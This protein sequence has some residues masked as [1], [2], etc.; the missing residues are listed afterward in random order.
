MTITAGIKS[1]TT[2]LDW[3]SLAG[4]APFPQLFTRLSAF[5][6]AV[7]AT[8]GNESW[9]LTLLKTHAS[10]TGTM[11]GMV[12]KLGTPV[13]DWLLQLLMP[14]D[15]FANS[16]LRVGRF[17]NWTDDG[18]NEGYGTLLNVGMTDPAVDCHSGSGFLTPWSNQPYALTFV[19]ETE[20]GVEFFY[21]RSDCT[22]VPAD[23]NGESGG[24]P[25]DFLLYRHRQYSAWCFNMPMNSYR[26]GCQYNSVNQYERV[27]R[28]GYNFVKLDRFVMKGYP[29]ITNKRSATGA[30]SPDGM[31]SLCPAPLWIG[32]Y[33]GVEWPY[34]ERLNQVFCRFD[35]LEM[36]YYQLG[37]AFG[38]NVWLV[39]PIAQP[40][41]AQSGWTSFSAYSGWRTGISQMT[42]LDG[43]PGWLPSA[44]Q[45]QRLD[46]PAA[47]QSISGVLSH[48][49]LSAFLVDA[50]EGRAPAGPGSG[51]GRPAEGVLWP[52]VVR[53]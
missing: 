21:F 7:N 30:L 13:E 23:P 37:R 24:R 25:W 10:S 34:P 51:P 18:A 19:Q 28:Q 26:S 15:N 5:I 44:L 32:S 29:L 6:A 16:F 17:K 48:P 53:R 41:A 49:V 14:A 11:R 39:L 52:R 33:G 50:I 12:L 42:F 35:R 46:A 1:G 3:Q 31:P 43:M 47:R 9:Q 38:G 2:A 45:P 27:E 4:T 20:P 36:R 40:P 8:P 22:T